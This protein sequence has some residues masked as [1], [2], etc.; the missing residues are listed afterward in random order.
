MSAAQFRDVSTN[1]SLS[2]GMDRTKPLT[3]SMD[4]LLAHVLGN[5]A[6]AAGSRE[7]EGIGDS[8]DRGLALL[9]MLDEAG[10]E[11]RLKDST[12]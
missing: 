8:I 5:V 9:R 10:F 6:Y 11:L 3:C 1:L 2:P 4:S 7:L 12:K